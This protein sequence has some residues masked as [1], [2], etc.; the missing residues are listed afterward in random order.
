MFKLEIEFLFSCHADR[1]PV[2]FLL[3][4]P[5]IFFFFFFFFFLKNYQIEISHIMWPTIA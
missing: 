5:A 2:L 4:R 3:V 1:S